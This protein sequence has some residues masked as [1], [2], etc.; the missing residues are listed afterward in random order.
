MFLAA[1]YIGWSQVRAPSAVFAAPAHSGVLAA[2]PWPARRR[3]RPPAE[4]PDELAWLTARLPRP[5]R[6]PQLLIFPSVLLQ[7]SIRC[8]KLL[9]AVLYAAIWWTLGM[10]LW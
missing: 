3:R 8:F 1:A 6:H 9:A 10:L 4:Q 2:R 5:P 7:P